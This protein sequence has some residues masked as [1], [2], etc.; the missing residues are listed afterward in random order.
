MSL[1][2]PCIYFDNQKCKK[3]PE[4]GYTDW[5]VMG[6]CSHETPSHADTIRHLTDEDLATVML[7]L[8]GVDNH[9]NFCLYKPEC[10][11]LLDTDNDIPY[12]WCHA[13][14][15]AWL[16]RPAGGDFR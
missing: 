5:C 4:P 12:E 14:M 11:S 7:R 13:C 16:Q 9:I 8:T 3:N 6:P 1:E 15:L 10:E 2:Y